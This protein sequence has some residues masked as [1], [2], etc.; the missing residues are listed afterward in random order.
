[1]TNKERYKQAFSSLHA[2]RTISLE[3]SNMKNKKDLK[4]H[5]RPALAACLAAAAIVGCMGV[6]YA[7]NV[8]GIQE[9]IR[10]W[11]NGEQMEADVVDITGTGDGGYQF[12]LRPETDEGITD[13]TIVSG[14]V[15]IEDD[16]T[17]RPLTAQEV[18]EQFDGVVDT[19][20]DGRVY[21][22]DRDKAVD[23]TDHLTEGKCKVALEVDGK[24]VYYTIEDNGS[25]GWSYTRTYAPKDPVEDYIKLD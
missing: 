21:I 8:G 23:I 10:I 25:G 4:F 18:A 2:S 5:L 9:T 1:M 19:G 14:G 6:A 15:A 20:E 13:V 24:N 16:G 7:A 22:Y 11:F 17:E 3:E 12:T